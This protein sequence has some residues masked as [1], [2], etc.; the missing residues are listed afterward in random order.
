MYGDVQKALMKDWR[1]LWN[2]GDFPFYIVQLPGQQNISNNPRIREEQQEV[3]TLPNT[4]M[5]ITIDIGEARDVHPHNKEPLGERLTRIALAN[6][7]GKK[8]EAYGPMFESMKIEGNSARIKFTHAAG[9]KATGGVLKA[10]Q[11]AG[12]D[13]K[14]VDVDAKIDGD[15]VVVSSK[16]VPNPVAVRYAF[17]NYPEGMGANLYNS[18]DLP[19]APFRTDNWKVEIKGIVED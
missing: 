11:V 9:M 1:K 18:D 15:N 4:G 10:F 3:L 6:A 12:A 16:D 5:A 2:S 14:F 17:D 7:Y 19:A 13:Q 8:I